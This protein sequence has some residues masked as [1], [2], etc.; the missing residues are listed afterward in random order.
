MSNIGRFC[1]AYARERR[2]GKTS[3]KCI[4]YVN[5]SS[6]FLLTVVF[7]ARRRGIDTHW[8]QFTAL[9]WA[10]G[11]ICGWG[12]TDTRTNLLLMISMS[13]RIMCVLSEVSDITTCSVGRLPRAQLMFT[14]Y[15]ALVLINHKYEIHKVS[16]FFEQNYCHYMR[17]TADIEG[18]SNVEFA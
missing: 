12:V 11:V 10:L 4:F 18:E 6:S 15:H 13:Q 8:I 5:C 16:F 3:S 17:T 2:A 1:G 9:E 7:F 14:F